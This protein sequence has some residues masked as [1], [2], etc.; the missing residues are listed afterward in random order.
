VRSKFPSVRS[1]HDLCARTRAEVRGNISQ[2]VSIFRFWTLT[3]TLVVKPLN[4][5]TS[6]VGQE[7]D[8]SAIT[9]AVSDVC[10]ENI[11]HTFIWVVELIA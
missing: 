2:D 10:V 6:G 8:T 7:S 9:Y 3:E 11:V 5:D 4:I 1:S